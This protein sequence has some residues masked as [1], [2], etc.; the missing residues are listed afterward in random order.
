ME[1]VKYAQSHFVK[2]LAP[3][4]CVS[5]QNAVLFEQLT[6]TQQVLG[7]MTLQPKGRLADPRLLYFVN[8]ERWRELKDLFE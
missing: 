7:L 5:A 3:L 8:V 6:L 1:A 4:D 2:F